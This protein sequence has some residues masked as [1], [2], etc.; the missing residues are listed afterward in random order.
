MR[1]LTLVALNIERKFSYKT[2]IDRLLRLRC[3][4]IRRIRNLSLT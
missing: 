1:K 2:I 3:D 4:D